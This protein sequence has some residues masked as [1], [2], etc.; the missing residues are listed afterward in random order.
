MN[1]ERLWAPWRL[2]YVTGGEPQVLGSSW[3]FWPFRCSH[4]FCV[5]GEPSADRKQFLFF[6]FDALKGKGR[7]LATTSD[8]QPNFD[9]SPDGNL[10]AWPRQNAVHF[11]SLKDGKTWDLNYKGD[12]SF[13][14]FDWAADGNGIFVGTVAARGG[15]ILMHMDLQGNFHSLWKTAYSYTWGVPSPDGRRLAILGGTQERNAWMLENF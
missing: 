6:E 11:L 4:K 1:L 7:Q 8:Q 12:W 13:Y 15:A 9:I 2:E 10:L 5:W 14:G 3:G